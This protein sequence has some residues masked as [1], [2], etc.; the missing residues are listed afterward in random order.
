MDT[1]IRSAWLIVALVLSGLVAWSVPS[2]LLPTALFHTDA[3]VRVWAVALLFLSTF[4]LW[5]PAVIPNSW[6]RSLRFVRWVCGGLLFGI[7]IGIAVSTLSSGH[8]R[9]GAAVVGGGVFILAGIGH[10]APALRNAA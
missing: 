4:P 10:I 2:A 1:L 6:P 9:F 5:L 7:G 3:F 8:M